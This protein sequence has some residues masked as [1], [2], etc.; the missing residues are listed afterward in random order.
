VTTSLLF[1]HPSDELYGADRMLLELIAA[2]PPD[3]TAQVWLPT[4]LAHPNAPLCDELARRGVSVRHVDLP[5][6]RRAYQTPRGLLTLAVKLAR[7]AE[8]IRATR[9]AAVYCTTSAAFLGIPA[10][11]LAGVQPVIGH[12][13]EIWTETD[14]RILGILGRGS[15]RIIA[16][17]EAVAQSLTDRLRERTIVVPNATPEPAGRTS[18]ATHDGP[19]TFVI[20]SRWN[21]WKGH[22]TLLQAWDQST[23]PG[24]LL[25]LAGL[26]P[27]GDSVDVPALVAALKHPDS[28]TIVGEVPDS[29]VFLDQADVVLMPS[30]QPEPFGLVA[31]EAFA[32][33]R[34]VIASAGGGLLDIVTAGSDGWFFTAQ[35]AAGLHTLL[36]G[37]TRADV[38]SAGAR[39]RWSY[40]DHYTTDLFA[41]RWRVAVGKVAVAAATT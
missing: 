20:A 17:S 16:I 32:R 15:R 35:D 13:Q 19:L 7:L 23:P 1:I 26:P 18:L 28:V 12:V 14:R 8:L 22:R 40:E 38:T 11:R 30:D 29:A 6:L 31:I 41:T 21:G 24:Q 2:L 5:I 39:A 36:A 27:S 10:A 25:I 37:L 33:G 3:S 34:P 4:D 9:P